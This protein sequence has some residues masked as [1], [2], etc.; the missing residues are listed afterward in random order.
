MHIGWTADH[1]YYF[2]P[3]LSLTVSDKGQKILE[4]IVVSKI[5]QFEEN[6]KFYPST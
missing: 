4:G 6:P 5:F 2:E 1:S 3:L